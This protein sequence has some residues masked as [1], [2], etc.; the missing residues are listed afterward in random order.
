[1]LAR[2]LGEA[3]E[4]EEDDGARDG[5]PLP[6]AHDRH[7]LGLLAPDDRGHLTDAT[8]VRVEVREAA[9]RVRVLLEVRD[10]V[11][12][13]E[14]DGK[15]HLDGGQ[16]HQTEV[17][18]EG[19]VLVRGHELVELPAA[20]EEGFEREDAVRRG[21]EAD[22]DGPEEVEDQ[23][24]PCVGV[25]FQASHALEDV[26]A[27]ALVKPVCRIGQLMLAVGGMGMT[28]TNCNSKEGDT[29]PN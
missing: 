27:V 6:E 29:E 21:D 20:L 3:E 12:D 14:G 24:Q 7:D 19:E 15:R 23:G 11:V 25:R 8:E 13:G 28:R 18:V 17:A 16:A 5:D 22:G 10:D 2:L 1:M 4:E 26:E 9:P